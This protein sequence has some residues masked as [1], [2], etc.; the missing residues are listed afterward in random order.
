MALGFIESAKITAIANAIRTKTNSTETMTVEEM[1]SLITTIAGGGGGGAQPD[2]NAAEGEPGHILNRPFYESTEVLFDQRVEIVD[3]EHVIEGALPISDGDMVKVTWNGVEYECTAG[4]GARGDVFFGNTAFMGG[5]DN[6]V[7]FV[8]AT[9]TYNGE[10]VLAI[11]APGFIG[12][13]VSVKVEGPVVKTI[14]PKFIPAGAGGGVVIVQDSDMASGI[15]V[16]SRAS[17][18]ATRNAVQIAEAV[19]AGKT[20]YFLTPTDEAVLLPLAYI[21]RY[22]DLVSGVMTLSGLFKPYVQFGAT[23]GS[24]YVSYNV[25]SDGSYYQDSPMD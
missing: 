12:Q 14:D 19:Q 1:P 16:V 18:T 8:M 4:I 25:N 24:S 5:E 2:W 20:V 6:G 21:Y 10:G 23:M 13:T 15:A 9:G 22:P 3:V 7:P 17:A 11:L